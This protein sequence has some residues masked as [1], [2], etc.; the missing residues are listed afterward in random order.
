VKTDKKIKVDAYY[1]VECCSK[2]SRSLEL[3]KAIMV[4]DVVGL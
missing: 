1:A 2:N 3:D 4:H